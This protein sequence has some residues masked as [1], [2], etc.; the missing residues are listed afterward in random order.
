[1][2]FHS[3]P[4]DVLERVDHGQSEFR[5]MLLESRDIDKLEAYLAS[6]GYRLA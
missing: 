5:Q 2:G 3:Q 1:M 6:F 4:A